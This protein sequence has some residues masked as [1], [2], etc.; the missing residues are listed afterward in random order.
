MPA[1]R[2]IAVAPGSPAAAA[3]VEVG[4]EVVAIDGTVPRDIIEWRFLVDDADPVLD[5]ERGGLTLTVEDDKREGEPLGVAIHSAL[6]D[7]VRTCHNHCTFC[8]IYPLTQ[9]LRKS[10]FHKDTTTP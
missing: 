8:F 4:D 10:Q 7:H 5:L 6:F 9:G 1:P 3:G 2:V